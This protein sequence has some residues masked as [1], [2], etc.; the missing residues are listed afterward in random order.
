VKTRE[1]DCTVVKFPLLRRLVIDVADIGRKRNTI[2]GLIEVD[3]TNARNLLR[4]YRNRAGERLSFTAFVI[5]CVARA[6][7]DDKSIQAFLD[8]R[9]RLV[10]FD[11]VDVQT[12]VEADIDGVKTVVP[13]IVRA[14]NRKSY[15]EIHEDIRATQ[16]NPKRDRRLA[17]LAG[18]FPY[19]PKQLRRIAYWWIKK[20]PRLLRKGIGTTVVT[21]VGMMFGSGGGWG[22]GTGSLHSFG[23]LLGSMVKKP[24]VVDG[25]IEIREYLYV[26]LSFNHDTVDGAPATRFAR[27]FVKMLECA[28]EL[29][30][31]LAKLDLATP[32]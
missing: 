1:S 20:R 26:G 18:W 2:R 31:D 21:S 9:N 30:A 29:K 6:L 19:V 10:I 13:H 22:I 16:A 17:R 28:D 4:Q 11:D 14:A 3:I 5:R 27:R 25:R 23:V 15:L 8:W 7:D 24:G 32:P 12:M